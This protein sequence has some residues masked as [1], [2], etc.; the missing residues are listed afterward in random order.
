MEWKRRNGGEDNETGR[1]EEGNEEWRMER[2]LE[3]KGR[4]RTPRRAVDEWNGR[5]MEEGVE[6][7]GGGNVYEGGQKKMRTEGGLYDA[8]F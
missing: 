5:V 8:G 2:S 3:E 1:R 4:K 7:I 6:F